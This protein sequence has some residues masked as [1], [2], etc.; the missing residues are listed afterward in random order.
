MQKE[1][2]TARDYVEA[3]KGEQEEFYEIFFQA[4][5]KF[6]VSWP[7]ATAAEKAFIEEFTRVTFQRRK[8]V[9]EGR[10]KESVRN[11]FDRTT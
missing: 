9:R 2:P 10:P 3:C 7:D 5:H 8:A 4:C 11:F 6:D 1:Y